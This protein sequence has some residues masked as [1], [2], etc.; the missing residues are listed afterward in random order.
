MIPL[1]LMRVRAVGLDRPLAAM[2]GLLSQLQSDSSSVYG[3]MLKHQ[4]LR[5]CGK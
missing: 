1:R 2:Q 5:V 3:Q 4:L